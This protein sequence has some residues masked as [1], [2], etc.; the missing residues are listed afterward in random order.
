MATYNRGFSR[1][2]PKKKQEHDS[3]SPYYIRA[4]ARIEYWHY[5]LSTFSCGYSTRVH[6]PLPV[7]LRPDT[8]RHPISSHHSLLL[9]RDSIP[10][11]DNE[12]SSKG[13]IRISIIYFPP[14]SALESTPSLSDGEKRP[15]TSPYATTSTR[16]YLP[17]NII[18]PRLF[19][20]SGTGLSGMSFFAK[21]N[22]PGTTPITPQKYT[23]KTV[24]VTSESKSKSNTTLI[25]KEASATQGD[26]KAKRGSQVTPLTSSSHGN[27]KNSPSPS[28]KRK[29]VD[30]MVKGSSSSS[31]DL[32]K[33]PSPESLS[34]SRHRHTIS[35]S[36]SPLSVRLE[37][38]D[39]DSST[40][41]D[42]R[43][44]ASK[45]YKSVSP[46][47]SQ[48]SRGRKLVNPLSF[49][50]SSTS[51]ATEDG[52]FIHAEQIANAGVKSGGKN[53]TRGMGKI[54]KYKKARFTERAC[55]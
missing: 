50:R 41:Q 32:L 14:Q 22:R 55:G 47:A 13:K 8:R 34:S 6:S 35:S 38:S 42:D 28:R 49:R 36:R 10:V 43:E 21:F 48:D 20:L 26:G 17:P 9:P 2:A 52:Y 3:A 7:N 15:S 27:A 54:S 11:K 5:L 29:H 18:F 1:Y 53:P 45:R 40:D 19:F 4:V 39:D 31:S 51:S 33:P 16:P 30:A 44:R 12:K 23:V 37:S 24:K 25:K 46:V